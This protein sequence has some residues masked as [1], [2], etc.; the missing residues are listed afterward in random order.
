MGWD[1]V[2]CRLML[3]FMRHY[4]HIIYHILYYIPVSHLSQEQKIIFF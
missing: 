1:E 3:K 2:G 4:I